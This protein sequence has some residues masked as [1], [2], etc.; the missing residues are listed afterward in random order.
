MPGMVSQMAVALKEQAAVM[1]VAV[2]VKHTN[3]VAAVQS[4]IKAKPAPKAAVKLPKVAAKSS[5]QVASK[6]AKKI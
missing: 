6:T 1:S 2:T 3:K 5:K 4:I